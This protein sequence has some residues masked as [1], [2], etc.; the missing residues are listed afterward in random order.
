MPALGSCRMNY[1]MCHPGQT[2]FF[3]TLKELITLSFGWFPRNR[4]QFPRGHLCFEGGQLPLK[5]ILQWASLPRFLFAYSTL[6]IRIEAD[7]TDTV[8]DLENQLIFK[9]M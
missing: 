1:V 9:L 4:F 2:H 3:S 7:L 6:V 8:S 5:A